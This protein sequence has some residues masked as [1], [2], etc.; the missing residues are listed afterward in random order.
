[1]AELKCKDGTVIKISDE[2]E[3]E[4]R[5]AF[6]EKTYPV[7]SWF[8]RDC[9]NAP[10][11]RLSESS[12]NRGRVFLET[13]NTSIEGIHHKCNSSIRVPNT[14]KVPL[15]TIERLTSYNGLRPVQVKMVEV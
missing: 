3:Q 10:I 1:M 11:V 15:S 2:T 5:K 8:H 6:G 7:G 12:V 14:M 9:L 13:A 4:L